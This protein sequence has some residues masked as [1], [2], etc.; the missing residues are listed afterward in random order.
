[1]RPSVLDRFRDVDVDL[2]RE[3]EDVE[4]DLSDYW[5]AWGLRETPEVPDHEEVEQRDAA[6]WVA[7]V[8]VNVLAVLAVVGK[9][10]TTW[11]GTPMTLVEATLS[12]L[13]VALIARIVIRATAPV[14]DFAL[15]VPRGLDVGAVAGSLPA[16]PDPESRNQD[17]D[18]E[19]EQ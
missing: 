14:A 10:L 12:V 4:P 5:R 6:L 3:R 8:T 16:L 1:M 11:I 17:D 18:R 7:F 19:A 9:H 13:A 15:G 2:E